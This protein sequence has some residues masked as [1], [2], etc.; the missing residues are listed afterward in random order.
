MFESAEAWADKGLNS[1]VS[2]FRGKVAA[3]N[4]AETPVQIVRNAVLHALDGHSK[5]AKGAGYRINWPDQ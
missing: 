1:K 2:V 4:M 5:D 3:T